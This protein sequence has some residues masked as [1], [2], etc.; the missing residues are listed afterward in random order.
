MKFDKSQILKNVGS[1]WFA[2][3][4]NVLVGIFLSPYILHRLGDTA[5]GLWI[6]IFSATGYYGLFDLGIRSSI[7]RYVA[8]YSATEEQ[9]ELNRL[10]NTA[11]FSYSGIGLLTMAITL[12]ASQ[13]VDVIFRIPAQ[14][15]GTAR[16]LLLMVGASVS[17]GFPL[18]MFGGILEG[19]Q[20]F[21]LLNLTSTGSS[22]L[23]AL[24][25]VLA[26]RR[27]R[28][29]LT[30]AFITVSLPL[31]TNLINAAAVFPLVQLRLGAKYVSRSSLRRI[32]G[33]SG[34]TFLII[35]AQRLRFKT[36]AVVIGAFVSAAAITYFT[37]GSR[38]VEYASETVNSLA[39]IFVPMSTQSH[40]KGDLEGLRKI[41]IVGNR[42]CA[43]IVFPVTAVLT[44]L[45]KSVI[46][47]WVGS[48]YVATS[49][50]ILL[51]LLYPM[52]LMLAQSASGRTLWGMAKHRTLAW[53]VLAEGVSNLV[54]S[55]ILV[56]PYG[57][58]GD[59][60]GTA[61]PLVCSQI[62]FLPGHL[63]RLLRIN[64][65]TYLYEAYL[66]PLGLS[67]PLVAVLLLMQRW[68]IPHGLRQLL[69]QFIV[70]GLVYGIGLAWAL[71]THR[72]WRVGQLAGNQDD[73]LMLALVDNYKEEV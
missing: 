27:G 70:G 32:A 8:K 13:Y 67:V 25:I 49:Y 9:G 35:I 53:V 36:D 60:V 42:A 4:V 6:L 1:S 48:K 50:P 33:Y 39:Q 52:T 31:V 3:G 10:A 37:I 55:V 26:L 38:L 14:F 57:I 23:R 51:V 46:E 11:L 44:V 30:V 34:T 47:V 22:L 58:M 68:F 43:F 54:L 18:G 61:I 19:L 20:R 16:W 73:E 45:G 41:L 66:F 28:G 15:A 72:A 29:L 7:V 21:Y 65:W 2:L 24:L 5:F 56:R 59:A 63:C 17:L 62:L 69:I 64:I 71:W 12:I 40:A